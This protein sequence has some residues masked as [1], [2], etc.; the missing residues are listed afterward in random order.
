M[1]ADHASSTAAAPAHAEDDLLPISALQH[2]VFCPRQF[3]LIHVEQQ[4]ADNRLTVE[5]TLL[6]ERADRPEV[7]RRPGIR[8]VRALAVRS[9]RLGLSGVCDVVEFE[10]APD[11]PERVRPVEY[12]R[13]RPKSD[14]CDEVQLCAQGLCLE[15]MLGTEIASGCLFYGKTRRRVEVPFS[16]GL[17]TRVETLARTAHDLLREGRTPAAEYDPGR[18]DRCSLFD[19]CRPRQIGRPVLAYLDQAMAEEPP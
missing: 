2:L 10:A 14:D 4:W 16:P 19:L 18:C 6:H 3:A 12:K 8:I 11:G 13:G 1:A 17:R 15:E 9:L 7:E 5:G